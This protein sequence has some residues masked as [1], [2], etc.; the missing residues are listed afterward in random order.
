MVLFM[1]VGLG[2]IIKDYTS[3][4]G[5]SLTMQS[6]RAIGKVSSKLTMNEKKF[7]NGYY[8]YDYYPS[9]MP[10]S[11]RNYIYVSTKGRKFLLNP[12]I[13]GLHNEVKVQKKSI[14]NGIQI[15]LQHKI[16]DNNGLLILPIL[17]Y[18]G[19]NYQTFINGRIV[20]NYIYKM[21]LA[22][23]KH[24]LNKSDTITVMYKNPWI[25]FYMIIIS[26]IYDLYLIGYLKFKAKN[27]C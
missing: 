17:G 1:I 24:R 9:T 3:Y 18:K 16:S 12:Q 27:Q 25:Y 10:T 2:Q 14:N 8:Y 13:K 23:N 26:L 7:N 4:K 21:N 22:I 6:Y 11:Y 15:K 19:L 5:A 20:P